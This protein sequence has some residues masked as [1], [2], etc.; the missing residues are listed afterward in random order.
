ME[1]GECIVYRSLKAAYFYWQ[2][3][4]HMWKFKHE[5]K[6]INYKGGEIILYRIGIDVGGTGIKAGIV[7]Y[8]GNI[9][10][11]GECRTNI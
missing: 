1:Y 5:I 9:I 3:Y 4:T 10:G 11:K 6:S 7:D 8:N 2:K